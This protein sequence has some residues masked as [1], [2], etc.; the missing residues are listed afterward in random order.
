MK[1]LIVCGSGNP[2]GFTEAM[3]QGAERALRSEGWEVCTVRPYGMDI[4]H[5]SGCSG[6]RG[7]GRCVVRDDMDTV[8]GL[9]GESDLL[10]LATPVHF[11]GPSSILKAVVDR[12]NPCWYGKGDHPRACAALMCGG[13]EN[14]VFGNTV[15]MMKALSATAGMEWAGELCLGGTDSGDK[16][17]Y[18]RR[19]EEFTSGL[20]SGR[21]G[22]RR[23]P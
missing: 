15:S 13:G 20:L 23:R 3:C 9:F 11:S 1:A 7:S 19:A 4:R 16:A 21:T 17:E 12:F 2:E 10:I 22:N 14:P 5:C 8:Y 6:C 18:G